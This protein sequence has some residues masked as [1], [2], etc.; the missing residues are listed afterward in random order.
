M[1]RVLNALPGKDRLMELMI[2]PVHRAA[3]AIDLPDYA[4]PARREPV[5]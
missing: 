2:A 5:A 1:L 4:P 3:T